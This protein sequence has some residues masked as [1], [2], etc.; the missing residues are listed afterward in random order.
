MAA[1]AA[2]TKLDETKAVFFE[3]A[4]AKLIVEIAKIGPETVADGSTTA[5]ASSSESRSRGR[6]CPIPP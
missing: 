2:M 5:P 3:S 1:S 6:W 4:V